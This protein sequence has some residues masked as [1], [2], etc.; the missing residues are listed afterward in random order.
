MHSDHTPQLVETPQA[1]AEAV[2]ADGFDA[3]LL[4]VTDL[5]ADARRIGI[6]ELL[7]S[8]S[9]DATQ[10]LVVRERAFG[11]LVAS[12]TSALVARFANASLDE[13]TRSTSERFT[14]A[15]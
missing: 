6:C 9:L 10:P 12:Y 13:G 5:V 1:L 15:A 11:R 3:H 4:A 2:A 7:A 8:V 14:V